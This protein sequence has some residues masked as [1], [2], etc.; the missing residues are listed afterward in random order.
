MGKALVSCVIQTTSPRMKPRLSA[1]WKPIVSLLLITPF[2]TEL[3]TGSLPASVFFRPHIFLFLAT[4]GY[5]FPILLLREFAVRRQLG[6]FGLLALGFVYGIFNEGI[7]A[8]TFYLAANVPLNNFDGY[9]YNYGIAIPWAINISTWHALHSLLYPMVAIYCFF[10]GHRESPW[11]NRRGIVCLAVPTVV[12]GTL[13]FFNR[14][15]DREAGQLAHFILMVLM[16]GL[17]VWIAT[18]LP[19][20]PVLGG[21]G[22]FQ[23]SAILL[24]GLGFLV[25][26]LVPVLLAGVKVFTTVFYGYYVVCFALVSYL[27]GRR[28]LLPTKTVLLFAAGDDFSIALLGIVG[29]VGQPNIEKLVTNASFLVVFA[30]VFVWLRKST[31]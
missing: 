16:S 28:A 9:G 11:L 31:R 6:I 25:L 12:V 5:G 22:I 17:L 1:S 15:E 7:L 8:K 23:I 29:G 3:L 20:S 27:I 19:V 4:V 2:L 10:P 24:G 30:G 26:I 18:K 14:S 13:I 21:H